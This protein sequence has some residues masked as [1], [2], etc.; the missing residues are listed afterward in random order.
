VQG[1]GGLAGTRAA[2]HDQHPREARTDDLVLLGL[3]RLHDVAHPA[4]PAGAERGQQR[5]L[6]GQ[7]LVFRG[8]GG[9]QVQNL[10]VHAHHG[11]AP[12]LDVT[13]APDVDG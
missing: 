1:H 6:A 7:P 11:P 5:R 8:I 3:D 4:G 9:R 10:I 12:G 13:A 2:L